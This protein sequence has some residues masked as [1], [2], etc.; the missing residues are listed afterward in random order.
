MG[1]CVRILDSCLEKEDSEGKKGAFFQQE[2]AGKKGLPGW[3]IA[4]GRHGARRLP[5]A[6]SPALFLGLLHELAQLDLARHLT[7]GAWEAPARQAA[8]LR[9]VHLVLIPL[10]DLLPV[11][12][13]VAAGIKKTH[14]HT[15][16]EKERE[17]A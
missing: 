17:S 8:V 5:N 16:K 10:A 13:I 11:P 15:R 14:T 6:T 2:S 3:S 4:G 9:V 1:V 12:V 7:H